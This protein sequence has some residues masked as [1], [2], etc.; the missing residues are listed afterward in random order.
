MNEEI[1]I[2]IDTFNNYE[3]SNYGNVRRILKSKKTKP[4]KQHEVGGHPTVQL[5]LDGKPCTRGVMKL[6][7]F[8]FL[9]DEIENNRTK[10][11]IYNKCEP[12]DGNITNCRLDN[13]I[14]DYVD[15]NLKDLF[16]S[17]KHKEWIMNTP[18]VSVQKRHNKTDSDYVSAFTLFYSFRGANCAGDT[19]PCYCINVYRTGRTPKDIRW[20][21]D[22][23]LEGDDMDEHKL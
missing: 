20:L 3:I 11:R 12:D 23:W 14:I 18:F 8:A 1:W 17:K 22:R 19:L 13:I 10:Y 7:A 5:Y 16:V 21:Y 4:V 9:N 2:T 6:V 15:N